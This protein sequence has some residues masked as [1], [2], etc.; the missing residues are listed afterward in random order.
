MSDETEAGF[1]TVGEIV[2]FA[3]DAAGVMPAKRDPTPGLEEDGRRRL[4]KAMERLAREEGDLDRNFGELT[5]Q[6]AYLVTGH[7]QFEALN[8][9]VGDVLFDVLD[10]Y[11]RVLREEGTFLSKKETVRWLISDHWVFAA[12]ISI[13]RN[14]AR[15]GLRPTASFL[16][17]VP[18]WYLPET[19]GPDTAWPLA[20]VI[21]W[22][23]SSSGLSQSQ[24]HKPSCTASEDDGGRDRD[25][26]NVQNWI[27]G[28]HLP[29]AAALRWTFARAFAVREIGEPGATGMLGPLTPFHQE[30]ALIA[31]FFARIATYVWMGIHK[32]FGPEFLVRTCRVFEQTLAVTLEDTE[33]IES[34]IT[35]MAHTGEF[36]I[37]DLRK[38]AVAQWNEDVRNRTRHAGDEIQA[39]IEA[40]KLDDDA[41]DRLAHAYGKLAVIPAVEWTRR[42]PQH[43]VPPGFAEAI[44]AGEDLAKNDN[45]SL[46]EID[47]YERSLQLSKVAHLLPWIIPWLRFQVFYRGEEYPAA[48]GCISQAFEGARYRAGARQYVI[49]NHYVEMAAKMRKRREFARGVRWGRY[50]G[51]PVRWHRQKEPTT[52]N[53]D[54]T[55]EILRRARYGI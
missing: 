21:W 3:Y 35:E 44:F 37:Q 17:D 14:I 26:D 24:F 30:G 29:S 11:K 8:R 16:P 50:M 2:R 34:L 5:Q 48:W 46:E 47:A 12:A 23:Y 18:S 49:L 25:I 54:S 55:M 36:P 22:I 43:D 20:K 19:K 4:Q 28:R 33:R 53:L 42:G 27:H 9:A 7:V 38:N 6:L 41:I 32:E 39:L 31:L 40:K 1:P 10:V 13:A 15:Y 45:L 52:E 51:I